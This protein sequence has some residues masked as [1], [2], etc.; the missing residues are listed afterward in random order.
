ME[1]QTTRTYTI[2]L[3]GQG[4]TF[5]GFLFRASGAQG[6]D[7]TDVL[8]TEFVDTQIL[9]SD[10]ERDA[11]PGVAP[12][13]CAVGVAGATH[14]NTLG[15]QSAQVLITIPSSAAGMIDLEV[16]AMINEN[17]SYL[18]EYTLIAKDAADMT[19]PPQV[20]FLPPLMPV[21]APTAEAP[22]AAPV[23]APT[24]GEAATAS[25]T[26]ADSEELPEGAVRFPAM[27]VDGEVEFGEVGQC[28]GPGGVCEQCQGDCDND[29]GELLA[30]CMFD[31]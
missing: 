13:S 8:E 26:A 24:A 25:P 17:L 12:A 7:L 28:T 27:G 11:I 10:G 16:T 3:D 4:Q 2:S 21:T 18:T 6:Q 20:P 23:A 15:K 14:V 19:I 31:G 22:V 1:F 30:W 9:P 5:Q 29:A